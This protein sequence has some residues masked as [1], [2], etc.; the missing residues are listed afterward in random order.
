MKNTNKFL[1]C[2]WGTSS[3][4]LRLVEVEGF[5]IIA[6]VSSKEGCSA[7]FERWKQAGEP[8]ENRYGFYQRVV[9]DHLKELEQQI[10]APLD[11]LNLV[12]SGMASSSIGM[13]ELPYKEFP[14]L[15]NGFD[16]ATKTISPDPGFNHTT[17]LIS[18]AKT[19]DDVMR[20]EE[21][22]LVG[23]NFPIDDQEQIF[24]HPGTHSKHVVIKNG[25]AIK[26]QTYMTGELFSLLTNESILSAS[27]SKADDLDSANNMK[28]FE[29]GVNIGATSNLLHE[30][31]KVRTNDLFKK[32]SHAENYF[33]LSGLLIG[34]ELKDFPK[35]SFTAITLAGEPVLLAHYEAAFHLLG[36]SQSVTSFNTK[37]ATEITMKCQ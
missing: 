37:D 15:T 3:F 33:Y 35:N 14:F 36:I 24:I 12:I 25:K 10:N 23:C 11:H 9:K 30:I 21:V 17:L 31:F 8:Q 5:R 27:V 2:D 34:S 22:Q 20:G 18:G 19:A 7:T 4:R 6:E 13:L 29:Q 32:L 28:Y 16:L 26:L 1:S